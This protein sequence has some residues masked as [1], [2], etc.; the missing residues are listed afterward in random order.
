MTNTLRAILVTA[1]V[2]FSAAASANLFVIDLIDG[3]NPLPIPG[4]QAYTGQLGDDFT[5]LSAIDI[6]SV[7][8]FD[9][10][11]NGTVNRLTW[12][13]FNVATGNLVHEQTIAGTGPRAPGA[14]IAANYAWAAPTVSLSLAPGVYSVVGVGFSNSDPNF[15]TNFDL[16]NLDVVHNNIALTAAGGRYSNEGVTAGLPTNGAGNTASNQAYN[17]GAASFQYRVQQVP[18]P[19]TL[20]LLIFGLAAIGQVKRLRRA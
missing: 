9:S 15:N 16:I 4:N 7:G 20:S 11:G 3:V 2:S 8:L 17:F 1:L 10:L 14:G 19:G 18:S 6:T 12:Q 13:L 5:V